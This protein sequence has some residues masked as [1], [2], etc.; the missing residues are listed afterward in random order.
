MASKRRK[1]ATLAG[2][3]LATLREDL[4]R[5]SGLLPPEFTAAALQALGPEKPAE[6]R[7]RRATKE[8]RESATK[9]DVESAAALGLGGFVR[10]LTKIGEAMRDAA[11]PAKERERKRRRLGPEKEREE[12]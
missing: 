1:R 9:E 2:D 7:R 5:L 10:R 12:D 6:K 3:M 4:G 11:A 8:E